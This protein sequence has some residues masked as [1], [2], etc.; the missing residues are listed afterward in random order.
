MKE[1]TSY[2]ALLYRSV[3][4]FYL[5]FLLCMST[6]NSEIIFLFGLFLTHIFTSIYRFMFFSFF[7]SYCLWEIKR[8]FR[9]KILFVFFA[10]C[11]HH[12]RVKDWYIMFILLSFNVLTGNSSNWWDQSLDSNVIA[13]SRN[14][15]NYFFILQNWYVVGCK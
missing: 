6:S 3:Q 1:H 14:K 8:H 15:Q 4:Y 10:I 11:I 12:R 7:T 5:L 9:L 2:F 13:E